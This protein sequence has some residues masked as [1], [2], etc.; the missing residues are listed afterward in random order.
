MPPS[1]WPD[2][3]MLAES[4]PAAARK[5]PARSRPLADSNA[6][7]SNPRFQTRLPPNPG[8]PPGFVMQGPAPASLT[9]SLPCLR[10]QRIYEYPFDWCSA[11]VPSVLPS[12]S[13][14]LS[15]LQPV[16]RPVAG[17]FKSLALHERLHQHGLISVAPFPIRS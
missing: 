11:A 15:Q 8:A 16:G 14:R 5:N 9:E 17:P 4:A 6:G 1:F 10:L 13:L 2:S 7:L 3:G 12:A